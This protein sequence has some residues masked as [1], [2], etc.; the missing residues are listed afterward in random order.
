MRWDSKGRQEN[1]PGDCFQPVALIRRATGGD[2]PKTKSEV[3]DSRSGISSSIVVANVACLRR[4]YFLE[5]SP[6]TAL[7]CSSSPQ[8]AGAFFG[9]PYPHG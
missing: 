2:D 6:L 1:S 9:D 5:K 4:F 3:T 7:C 8:K